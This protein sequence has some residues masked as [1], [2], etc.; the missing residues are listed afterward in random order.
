MKTGRFEYF[1]CLCQVG[2]TQVYMFLGNQYLRKENLTEAEFAIHV[3]D[4]TS[5]YVLF[6]LGIWFVSVFAVTIACISV[7][8]IAQVTLESYF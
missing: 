6:Q 5:F 2:K 8:K 7:I 3:S 1:P 4:V